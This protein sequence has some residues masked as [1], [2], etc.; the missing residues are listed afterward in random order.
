MFHA[1]TKYVEIDH[2]FVRERVVSK[3]LTVCFLCFKDQLA[4]VL[5]KPLPTSRFQFLR[6]KLAVTEV[7]PA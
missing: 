3:E 4:D 6:S 5:T 1:H 7:T 2:H